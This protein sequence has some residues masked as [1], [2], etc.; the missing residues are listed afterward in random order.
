[1]R[2]IE[3]P[4]PQNVLIKLRNSCEAKLNSEFYQKV[5]SIK[6]IEKNSSEKCLFFCFVFFGQAKKMIKELKT[7]N[8]D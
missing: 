3:N 1:M 2:S 4:F 8:L 6:E 5:F 7:K